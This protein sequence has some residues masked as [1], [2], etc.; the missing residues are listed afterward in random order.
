MKVKA[1]ALEKVAR[2]YS[3]SFHFHFSSICSKSLWKFG[4]VWNNHRSAKHSEMYKEVL[5]HLQILE[6]DDISIEKKIQSK[7]PSVQMWPL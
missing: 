2:L 3:W 4:S 6:E 5:E 7:Q 1:D